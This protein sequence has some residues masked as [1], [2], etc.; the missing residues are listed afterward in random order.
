MYEHAKSDVYLQLQKFREEQLSRK[1]A[2]D[3]L[4]CVN[5]ALSKTEQELDMAKFW[6]KIATQQNAE[7]KRNG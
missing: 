5:K 4:L 3:D 2:E 1:E 7:W 6:W